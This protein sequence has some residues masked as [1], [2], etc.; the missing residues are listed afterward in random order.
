MSD[1]KST[2]QPER[3]RSSGV[4]GLL[5]RVC[6]GVHGPPGRR[7]GSCGKRIKSTHLNGECQR[8]QE[9]NLYTFRTLLD[10][11]TNWQAVI[12][13]LEQIGYEGYLT[14]DSFHTFEHHP[15]APIHQTSDALGN[16]P[17]RKG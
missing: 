17:G 3:S 13:E 8:A 9:F 5:G 7:Y 1:G 2:T 10:G 14:F 6:V 15:E 16:M 4:V 11:T 12:S